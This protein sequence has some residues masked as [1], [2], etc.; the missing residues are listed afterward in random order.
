MMEYPVIHNGQEIGCCQLTEQGLYWNLECS[1]AVVSDRVERIYC[2][3]RRMGVLEREGE[4]LHCRRRLSRASTPELP[5]S[6]GV[7]TLVPVESY[8]PWSGRI[9]GKEISGFR[10]GNTLLFPYDPDQPCPCEP[11]ICFFEI[12]DNFWRLPIHEEWLKKTDEA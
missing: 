1:C 11:L 6:S 12:K 3:T 5:P 7:F 9:L 4:R 10:D 2:G 8:S